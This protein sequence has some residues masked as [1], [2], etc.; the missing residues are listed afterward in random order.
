MSWIG[1]IQSPRSWVDD[2]LNV[3]LQNEPRCHLGLI[4]KLDQLF[5][6]ECWCALVLDQFRGTAADTA[7][8]EIDA[9]LVVI[10]TW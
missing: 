1:R 3:R 10:P 2:I 9:D 5:R 4:S 8:T 6:G 7:D